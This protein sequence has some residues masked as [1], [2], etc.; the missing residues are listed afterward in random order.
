MQI[1]MEKKK[2][3]KR[4]LKEENGME[5]VEW[6]IVGILFAVAGAVGWQALAG[7]VGTTLDTMTTTLQDN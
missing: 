3:L 5:M 7:Q 1:Q 4:F 2:M 6:A